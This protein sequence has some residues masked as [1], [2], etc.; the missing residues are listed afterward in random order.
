MWAKA[1]WPGLNL[2]LDYTEYVPRQPRQFRGE[3]PWV[4]RNNLLKYP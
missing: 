3:V 2:G 4:R 1:F